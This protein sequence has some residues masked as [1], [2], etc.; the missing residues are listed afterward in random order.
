VK[1]VEM[2]RRRAEE[3]QKFDRVTEAFIV[4]MQGR[5]LIWSKADPDYMDYMK[6]SKAEVLVNGGFI[7]T[8][9]CCAGIPG[10]IPGQN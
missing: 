5:A 3:T 8:A 4:L 10:S 1:K 2:K 7:G 6:V 9:G